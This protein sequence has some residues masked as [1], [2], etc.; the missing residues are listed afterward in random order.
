MS[1]VPFQ[2]PSN[3]N[4]IN[5]D[6]GA[7][8]VPDHPI[9]PFIEGDGIG[10]DIWAAAQPVLDAAVRLAYGDERRLAW[11]EVLA[12]AKA[13]AQ[14]GELLPQATINAFGTYRVGI[15]GPLT[16]PVG[17]GFRSLNVAIRRALDLFACVRPVRWLPGVP[18]PIRR[19]EK[20]DMVVFRENTEDI[21][22]GIEFAEGSD[23]N[24]AF[25]AWLEENRPEEFAK[26]RFPRTAAFSI[27]PVSREG[28]ER[29]VRAA[30]RYALVNGRQRVTLVHKGN[31]MKATEGAFARW[32]YELAEHEFDGQVIRAAEADADTEDQVLID[33][34]ITDAAFERALTR[35]E[36]FDVIATMNLNGDYLSDALT[37]QVGGLG[38]APGANINYD[39]QIAVFESTH[40]TAPTLAGTN[41]ANPCSLILSGRM[42]LSHLGWS[43]AADLVEHGI[44]AAVEAGQVTFDFQRLMP[45]A[46]PLSTTDFG[47][48]VIEQMSSF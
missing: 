10:P 24:A 14:T 27:K 3:G 44:M 28:T 11:M 42:M 32:G 18:S 36:S 43:E 9:I 22:A 13:K 38:I 45:E 19:P 48:A 46:S 7:L 40:G 31:I 39:S 29:L 15:K 23:A 33:D 6:A 20:V 16:T 1:P 35:P 17:S 34:V 21:Y 47:Q 26:I 2:I 37:A 12:G 25:Q 4:A 8:K 41:K 30:I 5:A